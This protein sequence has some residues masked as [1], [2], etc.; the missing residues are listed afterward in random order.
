MTANPQRLRIGIIGIA[1]FG[2]IGI[3]VAVTRR[4]DGSLASATPTVLGAL[5]GALAMWLAHRRLTPLLTKPVPMTSR[6][7][8]D[9]QTDE[10][11][12][13]G[14]PVRLI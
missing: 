5:V 4:V 8:D 7:A 14:F 13:H 2:I 3:H 10:L 1:L 6:A 9:E 12:E 11:V